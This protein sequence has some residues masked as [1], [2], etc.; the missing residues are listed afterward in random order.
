M[1]IFRGRQGVTDSVKSVYL[2]D[3]EDMSYARKENNS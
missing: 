1:C 2:G 3:E